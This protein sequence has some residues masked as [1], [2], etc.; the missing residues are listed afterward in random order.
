[1]RIISS[2]AALIFLMTLISSCD[3][4]NEIDISYNSY[5]DYSVRM[6]YETDEHGTFSLLNDTSDLNTV[7]TQKSVD[8]NSNLINSDDFTNKIEI[9]IT[10][11][12]PTCSCPDMS[13]EAIN[14][15]SNKLI[16]NYN[17]PEYN[18]DNLHLC[19]VICRPYLLIMIKKENFTSIDFYENGILVKSID[20]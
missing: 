19:E 3:K 7:F 6:F 11:D 9:A 20:K 16:I 2:L 10:K 17:L 15:K 4:E 1:M 18:S 5:Q 14:L 8:D 13:I 12:L